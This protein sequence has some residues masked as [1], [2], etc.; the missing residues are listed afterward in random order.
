M[1]LVE[2]SLGPCIEDVV[3][4]AAAVRDRKPKKVVAFGGAQALA[5]TVIGTFLGT[6]TLHDS[7]EL[8]IWLRDRDSK[9]NLFSDSEMRGDRRAKPKVLV[10][11]STLLAV[12]AS[13]AKT[14]IINDPALKSTHYGYDAASVPDGC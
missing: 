2:S 10:V 14:W 5:A 12:Q 13:R 11:P 6:R 4:V 7:S 9:Y 1:D 8:G 3:R